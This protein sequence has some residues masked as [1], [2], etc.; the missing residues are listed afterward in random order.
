QDEV[1]QDGEHRTT[2]R[3]LE[4]PDG[5]PA[6]TD[7]DIMR[8]ACE[9]ST[10]ATSRFVFELKA[11]G[12]EKGEDAFDKRFA[13]AKQ[14]IIGRFVLKVDSNGPVG[15]GLAG[16][17]AHGSSARVST[18]WLTLVAVSASSKRNGVIARLRRQ[19][20]AGCTARV[21]QSFGKYPLELVSDH[22]KLS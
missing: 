9:A 11:K 7:T 10:A 19:N 1:G 17:V 6:Q 22:A 16:G 8:M 21:E 20:F 2:R 18:C 3:A 15:A 13:I 12:E 14:L 5:D 4:P